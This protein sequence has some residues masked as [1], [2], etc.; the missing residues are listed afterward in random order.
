MK[1]KTNKKENKTKT[2]KERKRKET[3]SVITAK[4]FGPHM[5]FFSLSFQFNIS[6]AMKTL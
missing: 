6:V 3:K 5:V 4:D 1:N 2:K